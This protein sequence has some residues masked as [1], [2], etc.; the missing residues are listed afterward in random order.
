MRLSFNVEKQIIT[1]TDTEK[2]VTNSM[3]YLYAQF[4]FS[5]EWTGEKTAVFKGK[6][7]TYNALLDENNTCLVPWEVLTESWFYVSVFCGDLVTANKVTIYTIPSGYEIGDESRVPTPEIYIQVIE[8]LNEIESEVDPEAIQR[9]VDEY[10]ADE[11][12]VTEADVET[13]VSQYIAEI[14]GIP[15]GGTTGQVL[16]KSSD[17]DYQT[18]WRSLEDIADYPD[19]AKAEKDRVLGELQQYYAVNNPVVIGFSTDQ[20]LRDTWDYTYPNILPNLRT[21]RD[22]TK[23]F[24]FNVCVLGGDASSTTTDIETLQADVF[25]VTNCLKGAEC[26]VFHLVG[27]HD[28]RGNIPTI[29]ASAVY[30]SHRTMP[31]KENY[32][33][34][35]GES[36]NCYYDDKSAKI[37][38]IFIVSTPL[39]GYAIT[40]GKTFL[41][42][43]L[44]TMPTGYEAVIF[45]HHPMGTLNDDPSTRYDDWNEPLNW[46]TDLHPYAD[47]IIVCICGHCH[48]D[49]SEIV[50]GILYLATTTAGFT[51]L[52]DGTTRIDK[53]GTAQ[54]TAYDVFVI[55]RATYTIH[56][57]RYGIGSNRDIAYYIPSYTNQIPI[58]T[59]TEGNI[60]NG[61]GYKEGTGLNSTGGDTDRGG[62]GVTGFIPVQSGDVIHLKFCNCIDNSTSVDRLSFYNSNKE[63]IGTQYIRTWSGTIH[64]VKD[65]NDVVSQFTV[66]TIS[67]N[68]V[69]YLRLSTTGIGGS[70]IIT[71]NE[72]IA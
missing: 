45:S 31:I 38:F 64:V 53:V 35:D 50:D 9:T 72:S 39:N 30:G 22:L 56:C 60:Y 20:H 25:K 26:P 23:E 48:D 40:Q 44:D 12:F 37:R 67:G 5:E 57:V 46:S 71:V 36:T 3:N 59:D 19:Y 68:T 32:S 2:V 16:V 4:M 66:P 14:H 29:T 17:A 11:D 49:R 41:L 42:N 34:A 24:P 21:M 10:L 63:N 33:V 6:E 1:R 13:I 70:S 8:K 55:D 18:E 15:T 58:S 27:N 65:E 52:N 28:G 69:A 47:K 43:A 51:E 54:C 7:E 62:Y 61:V